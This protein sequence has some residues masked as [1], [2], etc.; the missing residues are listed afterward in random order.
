[1]SCFWDSLS[2]AIMHPKLAEYRKKYNIQD[3]KHLH[4]KAVAKFFKQHNIPTPNTEWQN[5]KITMKQMKENYEAIHSY[6]LKTVSDGYLCSTCEPFLYLFAELFEITIE[7]QY[8]RS[9]ITY[10]NT[11]NSCHVVKFRSSNTHIDYIS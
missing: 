3:N 4:P 10:T 6:N 7:H 5:T 9:L 1:M 8:M 2:D 11:K